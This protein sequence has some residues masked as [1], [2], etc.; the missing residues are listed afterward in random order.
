MDVHYPR[1]PAA[2]VLAQSVRRARRRER[3]VSGAQPRREHRAERA[4]LRGQ[5]PACRR[6]RVAVPAR[7]QGS[8]LSSAMG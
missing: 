2:G 7:T 8:L 6:G 3:R 4:R 1:R 5:L